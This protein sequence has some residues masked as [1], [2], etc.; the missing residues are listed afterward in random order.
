MMING[1][2]HT[3]CTLTR[4]VVRTCDMLRK[5]LRCAAASEYREPG[6][7]WQ[8]TMGNRGIFDLEGCQCGD[9]VTLFDAR[10]EIAADSSHADQKVFECGELLIYNDSNVST[11]I[12]LSRSP[13]DR[14]I[15][16]LAVNTYSLAENLALWGA[17]CRDA[18]EACNTFEG[19]HSREC[20]ASFGCDLNRVQQHF[21]PVSQLENALAIPGA[22][23][24][25]YIIYN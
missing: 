14:R 7:E 8:G 3:A 2:L 12:V 1:S 25:I 23:E 6:P 22:Q 21:R 16:E 15:Y 13:A 11:M 9:N 18:I 24:K 4:P 5:P 20:F 10:Y 17:F 19:R